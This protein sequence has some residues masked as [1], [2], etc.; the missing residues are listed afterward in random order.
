MKKRGKMCLQRCVTNVH[1]NVDNKE[2]ALPSLLKFLTPLFFLI[3]YD[4]LC[5]I[6]TFKATITT[7]IT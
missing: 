7:K 3:F 1:N 4:K 6:I 2:E 5:C